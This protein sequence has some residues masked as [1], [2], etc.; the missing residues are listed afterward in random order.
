[1]RRLSIPSLRVRHCAN[2]DA[3]RRP[4]PWIA[5]CA[6]IAL[7]IGLG[8]CQWLQPKPEENGFRDEFKNW[9]EKNRPNGTGSSRAGLSG[10]A[11]QIEKNLGY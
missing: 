10:E 6:T 1:M 11:Q 5:L 3:A 8:G 9:G 7:A 2:C 4:Q